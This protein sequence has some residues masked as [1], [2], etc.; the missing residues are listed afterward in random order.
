MDAVEDTVNREVDAFIAEVNRHASAQ[1]PRPDV[2]IRADPGLMYYDEEEGA[3]G[4][5]VAPKWA[6]RPSK[7]QD[8]FNA[9]AGSI[10]DGTTGESFFVENF[11]W[12]VVAH[13]L[14]HHLQFLSVDGFPESFYEGGTAG[15]RRGRRLLGSQ[16]TVLAWTG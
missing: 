4:T 10:G 12:F 6:D 8:L 14:A 9:W 11:N 7:E 2:V 16:S 3:V 15:Q 5:L 1:I 13:E